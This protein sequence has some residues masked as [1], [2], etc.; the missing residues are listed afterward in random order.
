[1]NYVAIDFETASS[2]NN[3]ACA[4]GMAFMENDAITDTKYYL[5][6][7]PTLVFDKKNIEVHG[8]R[9]DDVKDSPKFSEVWQGIK[10]VFDENRLVFAHNARFDMS[11]LYCCLEYYKIPM[12]EFMYSCSIPISTKECGGEIGKS[13][14]SRAEFFGI[15]A[16]THHNALDDALTCAK[17]V[18]AT[19]E[20]SRQKTLDSFLRIRAIEQKK[21]SELKVMRSLGNSLYSSIDYDSVVSSNES[22]DTSNIFYGKNFVVTGT[23]TQSRA[24]IIQQIVNAGGIGQANV[25]KKTNILIVG[26]QDS[27]LIGDDGLSG[28]ERKVNTLIEGGADIK[29]IYEKELF[30]LF[31]DLHKTLS[32][33]NK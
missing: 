31:D 3:S 8:I 7:P 28:K 15:D 17:L 25:T 6:Q 24:E 16:G 23:F 11:V 22:I 30:Q 21:F 32:T 27:T 20:A 10:N 1:M 26:T 13:L 19:V 14:S 4:L 12:P 18:L 5:I 33:A 9:P 29:I 2:A